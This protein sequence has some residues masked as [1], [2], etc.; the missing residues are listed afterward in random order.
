MSV[1]IITM[2]TIVVCS[3]TG[4][5]VFSYNDDECSQEEMASV[6]MSRRADRVRKDYI[7][8]SA[9]LTMAVFEHCQAEW[10]VT[11]ATTSSFDS[12]SRRLIAEALKRSGFCV[13]AYC[14][15]SQG[16]QAGLNQALR[17]HLPVAG[18]AVAIQSPRNFDAPPPK[19]AKSWL[20]GASS[21]ITSAISR[22][23]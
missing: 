14:T 20:D 18:A 13:A 7:Q 23:R 1:T 4:G 11:L 6:A 17:E 15:V 21:S 2:H 8:L 22:V 9:E 3:S 10:P 5:H 12:T 16:G 19:P